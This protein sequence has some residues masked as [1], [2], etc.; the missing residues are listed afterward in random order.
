MNNTVVIGGETSLAQRV[1]GDASLTAQINGSGGVF[2]P[3]YPASYTGETEVTPSEETQTLLTH[4]LV[5]VQD[6]VI[7]PI[8]TN[9]GRIAYSGG[10]LTVY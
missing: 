9:Y 4:G 6:I 10:L 1:S 8:P 3:V 2:I 5:V 7:N